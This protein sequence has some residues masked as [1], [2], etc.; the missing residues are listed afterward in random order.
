VVDDPGSLLHDDGK[1]RGVS[2]KI[3]DKDLHP[4]VGHPAMKRRDGQG[5]LEGAAIGKVVPGHRGD[6]HVC[7]PQGPR[8]LAHMFGLLLVRREGD[9]LF[10]GT[11]GT[12]P[13]AGVSQYHERCGALHETLPH[14][15]AEG[16]FTYRVEVLCPEEGVHLLHWRPFWNLLLEPIW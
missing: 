15:R 7:K 6:D 11:E 5:E 4:G 1:G 3:G 14:V 10:Y 8:R 2:E 12:A 13:R 16:A 9:P